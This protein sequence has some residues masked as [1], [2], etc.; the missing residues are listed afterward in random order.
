V[1]KTCWFF[2]VLFV[3]L[4]AGAQSPVSVSG[5]IQDS[6]GNPATSGTVEFDIQPASSSIQYYVQGITAVAPQTVVCNISATGTLVS[7]VNPANPCTVWGND[8]LSPS[9]STY[10]VTFSPNDQQTNTVARECI[11]TPGPYNLSAPV[12]CPAVKVIPQYNN[13]TTSPIQSNLVP[14]ASHVFTLGNTQAHYAAAYIDNLF[15]GSGA[16][17]FLIT[18]PWSVSA[19]GT[20]AITAAGAAAAIINGQTISPYAVHID[21]GGF[22]V[23]PLP[24]AFSVSGLGTYTA[25]GTLDDGSGNA[26]FATSVHAPTVVA[27]ITLPAGAPTGTVG[28]N[29]VCDKSAAMEVTSCF[30][31]KGDGIANDTAALNAAITAANGQELYFPPGTYLLDNVAL[32]SDASFLLNRK[33]TLFHKSATANP[34]IAMTSNHLTIEGGTIDGNFAGQTSTWPMLISAALPTGTSLTLRDVHVQNSASIS[35]NV[36]AFCGTL[37][38]EGSF[39]TNQ[40]LMGTDST[41]AKPTFIAYV[42]SGGTGCMGQINFNYNSAVASALSATGQSPG[43]IFVATRPVGTGIPNPGNFSQFTAIGNYFW[44]Y[45]G[46][47]LGSDVASIHLYPSSGGVNIAHNYFEACGFACMVIKASSDVIIDSNVAVNAQTSAG[48]GSYIGT[49]TYFAGDLTGSSTQARAQITNNTCDGS[50]ATTTGSVGGV[51][52]VKLPCVS[53]RGTS[54]PN[55]ATDVIVNGNNLNNCSGCLYTNY[56]TNLTAAG[57]II[58]AG[59]GGGAGTEAA[60]ALSTG[61]NGA[62]KLVD[63]QTWSPNGNALVAIPASSLNPFTSAQVT[64][65]GNTLNCSAS[66]AKCTDFRGVGYLKFAGNTFNETGGLAAV[67]VSQDGY[68]NNTGQLVWD[69]SNTLQAGAVSFD[70]AHITSASG[71]L[72]SNNT[73]V[74]TVTPSA[75]GTKFVQLNSTT[76]PLW[77]ATG[78]TNTSWQNIPTNTTMA[79]AIAAAVITAGAYVPPTTVSAAGDLACALHADTIIA[80]QTITAGST[81]GSTA[82]LTA[83]AVPNYY[84]IGSLVGVTGA[85]PSGLNGGPYTLTGRTSTTVSFANS[86][87]VW[88]SGGTF[89]LWCGNQTNDAVSATPYSFANTLPIGVFTATNAYELHLKLA[90]FTSSSPVTSIIGLRYGSGGTQSFLYQQAS[91]SVVVASRIGD[92][93][94]MT[95]DADA[96]STSLMNTALMATSQPTTGNPATFDNSFKQPV[97]LTANAAYAFN[98]NIYFSAN[99]AG[100]AV[101]L[102][103]AKEWQQK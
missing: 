9:N 67:Y 7:S 69:L 17:P 36:S 98:W 57:N 46:N 93:Y 88:T 1:K 56:V 26:Y 80:A 83:T 6:G 33:A 63:N 62:V 11:S 59:S 64:V 10:T 95:W 39:F 50:G 23:G 32:S 70:W 72:V 37:T 68:S 86:S 43:G 91:A 31:L 71:V 15:L 24:A 34:M 12:F 75:I 2:F 21:L 42:G 58:H 90:E 87:T 30:G 97:T 52:G 44:G 19:G 103:S 20:G 45:G 82:T 96:V 92:A 47:Y 54:V 79:A 48:Q 61:M 100:N 94:E 41:G 14:A 18:L 13:I 27:G 77:I 101:L 84:Q 8:V 4:L 3:S 78:T 55:Y 25:T 102:Q 5:T 53:V 29:A 60:I 28:G 74:G 73:P 81:D 22:T 85:T 76:A 66:N 38:I 16:L 89:F 40:A 65:Q 99:T 35:V 49:Y 51:A